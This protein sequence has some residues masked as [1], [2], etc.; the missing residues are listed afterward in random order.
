[1]FTKLLPINSCFSGSEILAESKYAT[2]SVWVFNEKSQTHL[3]QKEKNCSRPVFASSLHG[4]KYA[5][6][7]QYL[8]YSAPRFDGRRILNIKGFQ[9]TKLKIRG[10]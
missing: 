10:H 8:P 4:L 7:L 6:S 1:V 2:R 3:P 9:V 5:D